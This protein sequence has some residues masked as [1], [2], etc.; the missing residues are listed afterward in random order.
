M[1]II[2]CAKLFEI[3]ANY[4]ERTMFLGIKKL[5]KLNADKFTCCSQ[6][7]VQLVRIRT[8]YQ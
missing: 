5:S 7:Q 2:M 8:S 1:A 6:F 3:K 4:F